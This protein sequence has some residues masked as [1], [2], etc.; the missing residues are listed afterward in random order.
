MPT[1]SKCVADAPADIAA[2]ATYTYMPKRYP[3][4]VGAVRT[5]ALIG[6]QLAG[7]WTFN[8]A[9]AWIA[10]ALELPIP[11][12]LTGMILL[13]ALLSLGI[14]KIAWLDAAGSLLVKH[15]AFFFIP[16]AVGVMDAGGLLARHGVGITLTLLASAMIGIVLSGAIAQ[17]L[18]SRRRGSGEVR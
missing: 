10:R 4:A 14:V 18:G 13:Y 15:L 17:C 2:A 16:V 8:L 3:N 12:N 7:L 6:L 1:A 5:A 9:G 11:G